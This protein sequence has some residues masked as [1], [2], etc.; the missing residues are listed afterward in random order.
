[1]KI[2]MGESIIYSW[3]KHIQKC[4]VVQLNWKVSAEWEKIDLNSFQRLMDRINH[5]FNSPFK[6]T[7]SIE[8]L[9]KQSEIDVIGINLEQD[10]I[11]AIDIAFHE[12]GLAYGDIN[13]TSKRVV[14]KI[15]RAIITLELYFSTISDYEIIFVSPKINTKLLDTLNSNIEDIKKLL[16]KES[17]NCNIRLISNE[18]FRKEILEPVMKIS[19]KIT[20]TSELFLRSTQLIN[21]FT[22][23]A[24]ESKKNVN[25]NELDEIE[26]V[27]QKVP[28]W[29]KKPSQI[30]ST[31][32]INYLKLKE[33]HKRVTIEMLKN[34]C[35]EIATFKD[36]FDQMKSYGR[37]NHAKVFDVQDNYIEIYE[38][39]KKIICDLYK[40]YKGEKI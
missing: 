23:T 34:S 15:F 16:E 28:R 14:K 36:N 6:K 2:E 38:P 25:H 10:K 24:N 35:H 7:K 4:K 22:D 40:N 26:K 37:K 13:E 19:K 18:N 29:F 31:I 9:I 3:L 21:L 11:Y 27:K 30:N 32:L 20:D 1:M 12:N 5:E 8:Q 33:T 39:V 17:I